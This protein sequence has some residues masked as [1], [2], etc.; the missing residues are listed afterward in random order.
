MNIY[1]DWLKWKVLKNRIKVTYTPNTKN[2]ADGFT[3][4]L[5]WKLF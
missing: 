1:N 5:K 3:K 2:I 4:H